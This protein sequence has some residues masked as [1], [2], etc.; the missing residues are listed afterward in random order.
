MKKSLPVLAADTVDARLAVAL[1]KIGL[2]LKHQNWAH[3]H[4]EG[5]SPTQAQILNAL[6]GGPLSGSELS[7]QLGVSLPTVSD[8]VRALLDKGLVTKAPDPRHAKAS[9]VSLT[10]SGLA[11]SERSKAWPEFLA[12]AAATLGSA[13][14]AVMN[15]ALLKM[16]GTLQDEG[17][18][19][20]SRMCATCTYFS[21]RVHRGPKPHHCKLVKKPLGAG[22]LRTDCPE[23]VAASAESQSLAWK[24]LRQSA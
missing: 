6:P 7:G 13:E 15:E 12:Q 8:A 1:S 3:A 20:I 2:A 18:V 21:A 23:H 11:L 17:L 4:A 24:V 19:P 14:K 10:R 5:L 16:I 9:L 22:E